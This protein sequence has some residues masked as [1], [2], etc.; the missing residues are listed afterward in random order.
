MLLLLACAAGLSM[1]IQVPPPAASTESWWYPWTWYDDESARFQKALGSTATS[2]ESWWDPWTWYYDEM[3]IEIAET[4]QKTQHFQRSLGGLTA[5]SCVIYLAMFYLGTP[6]AEKARVSIVKKF[7]LSTT[8]QRDAAIATYSVLWC[9]TIGL[10]FFYKNLQDARVASLILLSGSLY[11]FAAKLL[12][13]ISSDDAAL[14]KD[15][16]R[17]IKAILVLLVVVLLA[18]QIFTDGVAGI[19]V[20]Q[21]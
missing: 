18:F 13:G 2:T 4:Q 20:G 21:S 11:P 14:R 7:H 15:G 19:K 17:E 1:A 8:A 5:I 12:P 9:A 16:L 6:L 10:A 3:R